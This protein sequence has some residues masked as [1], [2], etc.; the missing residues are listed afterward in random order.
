MGLDGFG[1]MGLVGVGLIGDC[2][3]LSSCSLSICSSEGEEVRWESWDS[4]R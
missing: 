2:I 3:F 1:G 4:Y